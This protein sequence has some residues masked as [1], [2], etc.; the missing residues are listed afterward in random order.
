MT[1]E[2]FTARQT[3][4]IVAI[5]VIAGCVPAL[6]PILLGGLLAE[7]RLTAEQI[8]L[9]ATVEALGMAI[10]A[11]VAGAFFKPVRLRAIGTAGALVVA[12][13]NAVSV[14]ADATGVIAARGVNG[15]AS[16]I[17]LWLLV[18]MV[19]RVAAPGR[20]F[21]IYV[22]LQATAGFLLS[23]LYAAYV[24]PRFG[25]SASY[26]VLAALG[27]LL[28]APVAMIPRAYAPNPAAESGGQWPTPGGAIG[29]LAVACYLAGIMAVW[30][31]LVP[32]GGELG[33]DA[34]T[35]G[36][37]ISA[38]IGVQIIGGLAATALATRLTGVQANVAGAVGCVAALAL[39]LGGDSDATFFAGAGLFAF[40]W[41]FVPPFHLPLLM[42]FDPTHRSAMFIGTAQLIGVSAGP[43]IASTV[44]GEGAFGSAAT[45]A[46][47]LF[48][49]SAAITLFGAFA[50]A[51]RTVAPA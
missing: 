19:T 43:M 50:S 22:T 9:A 37:A 26:G 35:V 7:A 8:G 10:A 24:V 46:I 32:L 33:R 12:A 18:G 30:V 36:Y 38:A 42:G 41:M 13:A 5:A 49:A 20:L 6:Q 27:L 40:F 34:A 17:L 1:P 15:F 4:S 51:R 23:T 2:R 45:V 47:A 16:G 28:L 3:A 11:T 31:Y 14:V 44:V 25:V 21:A 48:A 39:L 29:L